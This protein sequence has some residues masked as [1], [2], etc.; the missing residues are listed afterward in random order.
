MRSGPKYTKEEGVERAIVGVT[1]VADPKYVAFCG[2]TKCFN[3]KESQL[4]AK[5]PKDFQP[6]VV[7]PYR[8]S[9]A[10]PPSL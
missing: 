1:G 3:L 2:S 8:G 9:E 10:S 6:L 4:W 5:T 7:S